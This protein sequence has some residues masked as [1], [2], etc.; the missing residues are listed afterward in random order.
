MTLAHIAVNDPDHAGKHNE[1]RDQINTNTTAIAA[2]T[3]ELADHASSIATMS[4]PTADP[5]VASMRS[6]GY[7]HSQALPGDYVQGGDEPVVTAA[8]AGTYSP[9]GAVGPDPSYHGCD[10]SFVAPQSGRVLVKISMY[11]ES[12]TAGDATRATVEVRSGATA[13]AGTIIYP[14]DMSGDGFANYNTNYVK[15]TSFALLTGLT[16]G[17]SYNAYAVVYSGPGGATFTLGT[18]KAYPM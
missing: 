14:A 3:A 16:P 10:I 17:N 2:N 15:G 8:V 12:G 7:G 9:S 1:E 13:H 5:A 18:A 11:L 4:S 6:L